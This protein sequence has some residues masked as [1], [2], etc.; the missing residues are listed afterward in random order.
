MGLYR[1]L[2]RGFYRGL[3]RGLSRY[4]VELM[5]GLGFNAVLLGILIIFSRGCRCQQSGGAAAAA[6]ARGDRPTQFSSKV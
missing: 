4:N 2:Y 5:Y 6:R 3:Y 1:E